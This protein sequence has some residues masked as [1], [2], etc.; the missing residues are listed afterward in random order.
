MSTGPREKRFLKEEGRERTICPECDFILYENPKI[1]AG[2][3]PIFNDQILLCQRAIEPRKGYWTL[4]AGFLEMGESIEEGARREAFEEAHLEL[5]IGPLLG[6]YTIRR[7][8]QIHFYYR[9]KVLEPNFKAGSETTA[10]E[11]FDY[12][13]IPW[14]NLAFFTVKWA[15]EDHQKKPHGQEFWPSQNPMPRN[16]DPPPLS[17]L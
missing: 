9:A 14:D 4:P 1:V 11:L 17:E 5:E 10:V 12:E 16:A 15:L 8:G 6:F 2:V 13:K 3:V 7:I